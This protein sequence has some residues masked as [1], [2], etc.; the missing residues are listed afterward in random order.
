MNSSDDGEEPIPSPACKRRRTG[1]SSSVAVEKSNTLVLAGDALVA[2][3]KSYLR[4]NEY[5]L[6]IGAKASD[7]KSYQ[8]TFCVLRNEQTKAERYV[9]MLCRDSTRAQ[10][11]SLSNT[12]NRRSH[13]KRFHDNDVTFP[14]SFGDA[15]SMLVRDGRPQQPR[16]GTSFSNMHRLANERAVTAPETVLDVG[17]ASYTDFLPQ[18]SLTSS[19]ALLQRMARFFIGHNIPMRVVE[20]AD[21]ISMMRTAIEWP[22]SKITLPT[23]NTFHRRVE[24]AHDSVMRDLADDIARIFTFAE[25]D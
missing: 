22:A 12:S 11:Q 19:E 25:R 15:I 7:A 3:V 4:D 20:S 2:R 21:F 16:I 10:N 24:R 17:L 13:F 23:R 9:C 6:R 1:S 8:A 14:L 18:M 5:F